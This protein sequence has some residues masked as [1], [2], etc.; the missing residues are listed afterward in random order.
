VAKAKKPQQRAKAAVASR[1]YQKTEAEDGRCII[2]GDPV[3]PDRK[4]ICGKREC[5][6]ARNRDANRKMRANKKASA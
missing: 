3:A 1:T 6:R 2:C 4:N 5:Q